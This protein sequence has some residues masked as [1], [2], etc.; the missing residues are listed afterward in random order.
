MRGDTRGARGDTRGV[1]DDTRGVRDDT[2]GA[3]GDTRGVRGDTRAVLVTRPQSVISS[4][5]CVLEKELAWV[6]LGPI[7][8]RHA[9]T[10]EHSLYN[11]IAA[12]FF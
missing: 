5:M 11:I 10:D 6:H 12:V 3:R 7:I 8:F 9:C 4:C 2:R 1:R